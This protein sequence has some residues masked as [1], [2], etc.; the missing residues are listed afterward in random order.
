MEHS[1]FHLMKIFLPLHEEKHALFVCCSIRRSCIQLAANWPIRVRV[2]LILHL[3]NWMK[4]TRD[5]NIYA[6]ISLYRTFHDVWSFRARVPRFVKF[7]LYQI[8]V[9]NFHCSGNS[10]QMYIIIV[11][12]KFYKHR[13]ITRALNF[14]TSWKFRCRLIWAV[15]IYILSPFLTWMY[16]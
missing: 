4:W 9:W 2:I 7:C 6:K 5:W 12:I 1:I 11:K 14:Q 3:L 8:F 10:I 15:K 13:Y 16:R